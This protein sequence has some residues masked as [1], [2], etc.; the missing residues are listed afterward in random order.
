MIA[1][2]RARFMEKNGQGRVQRALNSEV[3]REDYVRHTLD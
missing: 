3:E 2:R 1:A